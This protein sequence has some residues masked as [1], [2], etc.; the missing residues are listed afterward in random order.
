MLFS[1][2]VVETGLYKWFSKLDLRS[3]Y[4]VLLIRYTGFEAVE[5]LYQFKSIP[6][7]LKNAV[8]FFF[9]EQQIK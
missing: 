5:Q 9:K 4:H 7:G 3:S 2:L 1:T 6:F 8:S